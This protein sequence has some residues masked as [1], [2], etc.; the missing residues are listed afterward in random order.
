LCNSDSAT[1]DSATFDNATCKSAIC[2]NTKRTELVFIKRAKC[3]RVLV[4]TCVI[5]YLF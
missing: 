2:D 5:P 1:C 3:S 4:S